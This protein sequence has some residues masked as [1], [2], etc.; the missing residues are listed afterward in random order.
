MNQERPFWKPVV[1]SNDLLQDGI[2]FGGIAF[3]DRSPKLLIQLRDQRQSMIIPEKK[4]RAKKTTSTKPKSTRVKKKK[5]PS[6]KELEAMRASIP[7]E[8]L[9]AFDNM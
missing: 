1:S 4:V 3:K 9:A 2:I 8:I 5:G 7:P 6:A